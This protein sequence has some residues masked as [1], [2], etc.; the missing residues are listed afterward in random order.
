MCTFYQLQNYFDPKRV[1]ILI[2]ADVEEQKGS[3][4]TELQRRGF[5]VA[6]QMVY[7]STTKDFAQYVL[8]AAG[9]ANGIAHCGRSSY[10]FDSFLGVRKP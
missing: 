8:Q 3:I 9:A 6:T 10:A 1:A 5:T 2:D 4:Q 7:P